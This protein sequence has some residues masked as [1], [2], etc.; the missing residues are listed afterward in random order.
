MINL[1]NPQAGIVT[2]PPQNT[3]QGAFT[4]TGAGSWIEYRIKARADLS[5]CLRLRH[6]CKVKGLHISEG[7]YRA[8]I[9][10]NLRAL[11]HINTALRLIAA[12][13]ML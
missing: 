7:M 4:L 8:N 9:N 2:P 12:K 3:Y 10:I 13:G 1:Q 6:E 11:K 5:R